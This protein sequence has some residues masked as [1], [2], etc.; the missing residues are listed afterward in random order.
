MASILKRGPYQWQVKIRRRGWPNQT[1]TFET[2]EDAKKWAR[3][4]EC[5]MD[6]GLFVSRTEAE[7]TTIKEALERYRKEVTSNK[8]GAEQ[9]SY[10]I[11][12]F[13][14]S[15]LA[16]RYLA[17]IRSTDVARYRDQRLSSG[18]SPFTVNNELI[19]LSH[20]FSVAS[21]EWGMESIDNPVSKVKRPKLP[22]GRERRLLPGE[23]QKLLAALGKT[24]RPLAILAIE[25]AM[26]RGELLSLIW[27]NVDL[28]RSVALLPDTK[29]GTSRLVP[30]STRAIETLKS[31]R[32]K[33]SGQVFGISKHHASKSFREAC[34]KANIKNLR[35][36][37]LRHEA[38][39]RFFEKGL[40][41]MEVSSITGHKTLQMLKRYTHLKAEDLAK[42]LG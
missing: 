21:R 39:S 22:E 10:R 35:F 40:N 19:L 30:L 29:N 15:E 28:E 27:E 33:N 20:L 16:P 41:P 13:I 24:T 2:E 17:S 34:Q 18:A 4:I 26:R 6:R 32:D 9:E 38:T 31:L 8:K 36:H 3:L 1:K 14:R 37:D 11:D 12:G 25:T 42:K 5:E 7:K 23:E